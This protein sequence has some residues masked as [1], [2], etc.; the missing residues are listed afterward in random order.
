MGEEDEVRCARQPLEVVSDLGAAQRHEMTFL[1]QLVVR[2]IHLD[3]AL[4]SNGGDNGPPVL[5]GPG[6]AVNLLAGGNQVR[7]VGRAGLTADAANADS[8]HLLTP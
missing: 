4:L 7:E 8:R 3:A 2:P 1:A 5:A 6:V